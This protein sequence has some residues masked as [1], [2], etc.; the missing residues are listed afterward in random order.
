MTDS[1]GNVILNAD[2]IRGTRTKV[3]N[4]ASTAYLLVDILKDAVQNGT[5]KNAR[6]EGYEV[7]G[8]TGTNSDYASVFF[9]GMTCKY[10]AV[11]WIG[12]DQPANK[13]EK[14]STGGDAAA[15]LWQDFM[16]TLMEGVKSEPIIEETPETLGLLQRAVCPVSGKL[17]SDACVHY[18]KTGKKFTLNTDW[19]SYQNVPTE[20]CDMHVTLSICKRSGCLATEYCSADNIET[21]TF[22]LLRPGN[23]FYDLDDKVLDKIFGDTWVRTDKSIAQYVSEFP[24]CTD[25]TSL[26]SM[27]QKGNSLIALVN[28][29]FENHTD[30]DR[31]LCDSLIA[32]MQEA[33][34]FEVYRNA[35][36]SLLAE[37]NR[38]LGEYGA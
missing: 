17:A 25:D 30:L 13:L 28:A 18:Q 26:E 37:Y 8:K 35:Y 4:D 2:V 19:F 5:G 22:V 14:G 7:A 6:I 33:E 16:S 21:K 12:H 10:T 9:A 3:F 34:E 20:T 31:T 38:L 36:E 24:L 29:F 23:Q 27:Q 1:E 32:T 15:P 11:L